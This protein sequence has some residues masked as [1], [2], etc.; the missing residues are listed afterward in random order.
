MS[1]PL[2]Q[3]YNE[4]IQAPATAFAD[5]ALKAGAVECNTMALPLPRS[6]NFADVYRVRTPDGKSWAV[7]CFTRK[8]EG[9]QQRYARIH[10]HLKLSGLPFTVGF[11]FLPD[12]IRVRGQWYPV[13]KM[14]WVEGPAL[15]Q[16]VRDSAA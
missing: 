11:Q 12:G 5:A 4:A 15:N 8:V 7:K 6:G 1:W 16:L 3:D 14:E 9:L 10:D 13:L 2:S